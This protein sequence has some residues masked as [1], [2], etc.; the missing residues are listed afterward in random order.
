M[1]VRPASWRR[2]HVAILTCPAAACTFPLQQVTRPELYHGE[3]VNQRLQLQPAAQSPGLAQPTLDLHVRGRGP[4]PATLH[5]PQVKPCR[6][7][8]MLADVVIALIDLRCIPP[9][10]CAATPTIQVRGAAGAAGRQAALQDLCAAL[11]QPWPAHHS[12]QCTCGR[13]C[14][15]AARYSGLLLDLIP[16]LFQ[17][18]GIPVGPGV[19]PQ[20]AGLRNLAMRRPCP[21]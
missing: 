6:T 7:S 4:L 18:A 11:Q 16:T 12:L 2:R 21:L 5:V 9:P 14:A 19:H 17:Q 10:C 15:G 3:R 8:S 1:Q 13:R 20:G